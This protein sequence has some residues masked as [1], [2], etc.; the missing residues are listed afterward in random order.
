MSFAGSNTNTHVITIKAGDTYV[1]KK[2]AKILSI[3][4]YGSPTINAPC[5]D[6]SNVESFAC[7]VIKGFT[8]RPNHSSTT[9]N[10]ESQNAQGIYIGD[11][12]Y[13][14]STIHSIDDDHVGLIAELSSKSPF[15]DVM[16][17]ICYVEDVDSSRGTTFYYTFLSI[18]SIASIMKVFVRVGD[19]HTHGQIDMF[20]PVL[21][22]D[23]L[24]SSDADTSHTCGCGA[25]STGGG[26]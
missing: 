26:T 18:P 1:L 23:Y 7:Y 25:A 19:V 10:G 5:F 2:T 4:S 20:Y 17:D 22:F 24:Q 9:V 3:A 16:R 14:F 12:Y 21:S 6:T 11:T 13:A 8:A 15:K